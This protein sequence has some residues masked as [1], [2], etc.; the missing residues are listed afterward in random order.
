LLA[1]F[2]LTSCAT[3]WPSL[4][5]T[6]YVG[7]IYNEPQ[8]RPEPDAQITAVRPGLKPGLVDHFWMESA[9]ERDGAIGHAQSDEN[10]HFVLTSTGGYATQLLVQ[11]VN[12]DL[13]ALWD[14]DLEHGKENLWIS[15][16]P[17]LVGISY[18]NVDIDKTEMK[19]F[20]SACDK[21]MFHLAANDYHPTSSLVAYHRDGVISDSEY[22]LLRQLRPHLLGPNPDIEP[23]WP[24]FR[25]RIKSFDQ[26]I[27]I[28]AH[29][30]ENGPYDHLFP[31]PS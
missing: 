29:G 31:G 2:V 10:G 19:I 24:R 26:P 12:G 21:I 11:S 6:T 28:I 14:R 27:E 23:E 4:P 13:T 3:P 16:R 7:T 20:R 18:R 22:A 25:W 15:I 17:E 1:A 8:R 30:F 9:S 5:P